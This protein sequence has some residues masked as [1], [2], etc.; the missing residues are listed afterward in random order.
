MRRGV[1]VSAVALL[2]LGTFG[3]SLSYGM[4]LLLPLYVRELGGNEADFG[5]ILSSAAVPAV[6]CIGLL[7]R[8]PGALRPHTVVALAIA[9]YA[10]AAAGASLVGGSWTPLVGIGVL[11]GTAWAVVYTATPMVMSGMVTD[12]GRTAYFGYLTGT[13]QVGI[14][15]GPVVARFL[16][17]TD[18]GFRGTFLA[19][20]AVCLAA[21]VLTVAVGFLTPG[22]RA[23][24]ANGRAARAEDALPGPSFA[25]AIGGILRS[26]AVF[27]LAM[28]MHFA[29]LFTSLTQF[30]TTLAA[31]QNLD[32]SVFYVAYTV[33]VIV[34]RFGLAPLA[35]RFDT[36]LVIAASVSVMALAVA[37]FL[38]VGEST[39]LYA[40]ASGF[41]GLGYGLAL[42]SVQAQ[43]VNVSEED[44]RPRVLPLAGLLFQAAILL[45][46]L[47]AG[48]LIAAFGYPVLFA[49]LVFFAAAQAAIAWWR[50][51]A[52][53]K[54]EKG[55]NAR[56]AR[57]HGHGQSGE[58]GDVRL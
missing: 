58:S 49:V 5:V 43:A 1:G 10:A 48:W 7:I 11:L 20:G 24:H 16:V 34:S 13:Q 55:A 57:A 42:P 6:A 18:L 32:Y 3:I 33:A 27:P 14:G 31:A 39:P 38:T 54:P 8:Y 47:A 12:E 23:R 40:A 19:A 45:F 22:P 46:P 36:R 56:P 17:E 21:A 53:R 51:F 35:S 30:Q 44:L 37:G 9:V 26:E 4:L 41:V 15:A 52:A 2:L 50:V 25:G 28:V 29:C